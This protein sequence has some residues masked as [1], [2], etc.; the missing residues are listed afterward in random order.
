M[1][2]SDI[3]KK[4]G[5]GPAVE[6][7][8][9]PTVSTTQEIYNAA[10]DGI[11]T[12]QGNQ[13]TGPNAVVQYGNE[14]Q[15]FP[16]Q[17]KEIEGPMLPQFDQTTLPKVGEGIME[18]SAGTS[19]PEPVVETPVEQFTIDPCPS[20]YKL[21]NGVCQLIQQQ[22]KN[23]R[24]AIKV[25]KI[26]N[27]IIEGYQGLEDN[28]DLR[29][30]TFYNTLTDSEKLNYNKA[31][32][33][34]RGIQYKTLEDGTKKIIAK[35]PD[36]I[37]DVLNEF[38]PLVSLYN[39]AGEIAKKIFTTEDTKEIVSEVVPETKKEVI[40]E[41]K[42]V[43]Q[44][45]F[46]FERPLTNLEQSLN[47]ELTGTI[48]NI[49]NREAFLGQTFSNLFPSLAENSVV[50]QQKKQELNKEIKKIKKL[51]EKRLK[52]ADRQFDNIINIDNN[53]NVNTLSSAQK[54]YLD[55]GQDSNDN[56][57]RKALSGESADADGNL[58]TRKGY[59]E[60]RK[61]ENNGYGFRATSA[62]YN[63]KTKTFDQRFK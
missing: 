7:I 35:S 60:D 6:G 45:K 42:T 2:L 31:I 39:K 14:Q 32:S 9:M 29:K 37:F 13:Y 44:N 4:Y 21:I 62:N 56:R 15:G 3:L 47:N 38:N 30:G 61:N 49:F 28:I 23:D 58:D 10:T 63:K 8:M 52:S 18:A 16:R 41:T 43:E 46:D 24:P 57:T 55:I 20:G 33:F 36:N 11:M 1:A 54:D 27:G 25:P 17:L 40:P 48:Q 51:K 53:S 59:Q 19:T 12:V 5:D 50:G 22:S 26:T 34:G